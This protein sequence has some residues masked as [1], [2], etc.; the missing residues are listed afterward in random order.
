MWVLRKVVECMLLRCVWSKEMMW[1]L[2][3]FSGAEYAFDESKMSR[4]EASAR[5]LSKLLDV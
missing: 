1:K 5:G 3:V 2:R 4:M